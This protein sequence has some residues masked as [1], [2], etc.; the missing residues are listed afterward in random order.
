MRHFNN[1]RRRI[2]LPEHTNKREITGVARDAPRPEGGGRVVRELAQG[3]ARRRAR[4]GTRD[5]LPDVPDRRRVTLFSFPVKLARRARTCNPHYLTATPGVSA[6][7][8]DVRGASGPPRA[9]QP[10]RGTATDASTAAAVEDAYHLTVLRAPRSHVLS[11]ARRNDVAQQDRVS[12]QLRVTAAM[13]PHSPPPPP[14]PPLPAQFM[15]CK[16]GPWGLAVTKGTAF[17]RGG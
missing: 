6:M 9:S 7:W 11:Q 17:P 14:P 13:S 10:E 16:Y 2:R 1:T 3:D 4:Q 12:S 8:C 5:L 15:Y